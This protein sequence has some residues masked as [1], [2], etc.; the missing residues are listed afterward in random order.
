[1]KIRE[2]FLVDKIYNYQNELLA[3][4]IYD[5]NNKLVK[6]IITVHN[7]EAGLPITDRYEDNFVYENGLV[8]KII[9]YWDRYNSTNETYLF[10]NSEKQLI[11]MKKALNTSNYHYENGNVVSIYG[12]NEKPFQTNTIVY[13]KSKNATKHI[14]IVPKLND[15]G[16]PIQGKHKKVTY[17]YEYD[18]KPKPNFGIDYLFVYCALP[19]MGTEAGFSR[20]LSRTNLT[21][22]VQ[23]G[24]TWSYTYNEN[25]LPETIETRW[26][27]I[28]TLESMLLR[29]TYRQIE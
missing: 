23:S 12:D 13:N 5:D 4:Y 1:M 22:Y 14:H 10:Y 8:S 24:T 16:E 29:I 19:Q 18:N 9:H 20:E 28:E 3:E 7:I 11:K 6:R 17:N 21:K 25:G 15:F 27:G 2:K 26:N